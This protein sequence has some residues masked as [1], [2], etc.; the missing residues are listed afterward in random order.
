[1]RNTTNGVIHTYGHDEPMETK[2][3][4]KYGFTFLYIKLPNYIYNFTIHKLFPKDEL[5]IE[6]NTSLARV[7]DHIIL[8]KN[9]NSVD[10][11]EGLCSELKTKSWIVLYKTT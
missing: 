8:D 11:L 3:F 5:I 7:Y 2:M 10:E 4:N 1:M 6:L 9:W